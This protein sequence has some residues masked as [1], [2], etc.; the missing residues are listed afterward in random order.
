MFSFGPTLVLNGE[1]NVSETDEVAVFSTLGNQRCSIGFVDDLHYVFAVCDGR[2]SDS[3]GMCLYQMAD[4]MISKGCKI[5]YNLDGGGSATMYFNGKLIN[6][7]N[8]NGAKDIGEREIS[9]CV[10]IAQW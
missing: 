7:P 9:D 6:R 1:R 3:W 8:T 2:L 5:A 10:Y 4:F